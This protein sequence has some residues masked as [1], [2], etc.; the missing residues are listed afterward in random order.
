[1]VVVGGVIP[2]QDYEALRDAGAAAI[3]PPGTPVA[4]PAVALIDALNRASAT[5]PRRSA[6]S[7]PADWTRSGLTTPYPNWLTSWI[8]AMTLTVGAF[9][10]KTKFS[11][12][13]D[14]VENGEDVIITRRGKP[15]ARLT[16]PAT[17]EGGEA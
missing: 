13:L 2:P 9:E 11:E 3:F 6:T 17:L 1:M 8:H 10:A 7:R 15:V 14:R 5:S 16:L 12:L 4:E